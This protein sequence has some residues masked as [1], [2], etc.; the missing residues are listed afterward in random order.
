[1]TGR[2]VAAALTDAVKG[3]RGDLAELRRENAE[4]H[5]E[6]RH[7]LEASIQRVHER[8]DVVALQ[9]EEN[10]RNGDA[11]LWR[12]IGGLRSRWWSFGAAVVVLLLGLAGGLLGII[13]Y[14]LVNDLPW[15]AV[16]L[17]RLLR[18]LA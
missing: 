6:G 1:M 4:Q 13:G 3:L 15:R 17:A 12:A 9:L 16:D 11:E 14:V 18:W 5:R 7:A 2:D 10:R 8:I